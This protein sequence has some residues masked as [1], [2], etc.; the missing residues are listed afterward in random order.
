MSLLGPLVL[1]WHQIVQ[2]HQSIGGV[3]IGSMHGIFTYIYHKKQPNVGKYTIHGSYGVVYLVY[4]GKNLGDTVHQPTWSHPAFHSFCSQRRKAIWGKYIA[5]DKGSHL[6]R[7][8]VFP[9]YGNYEFPS[10]AILWNFLGP[11]CHW[12]PAMKHKASA[13]FAARLLKKKVNMKESCGW[14]WW[15]SPKT[16]D[17]KHPVNTKRLRISQFH[18][19]LSIC[20]GILGWFHG[21]FSIRVPP[22]DS[23]HSLNCQ[24]LKHPIIVTNIHWKVHGTCPE[25]IWSLACLDLEIPGGENIILWYVNFQLMAKIPC[26]ST[27][28]LIQIFRTVNHK[29]PMMRGSIELF[30]R[31]RVCV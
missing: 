19:P 2:V 14:K 28:C 24:S 3:P 10:M 27:G 20:V 21:C 11:P 16:I 25:F 18:H 22:I 9:D 23:Q 8:I 12:L 13:N 5:N 31:L 30:R 7:S 1:G 26:E 29:F 15:G 6:Q 4:F 17:V